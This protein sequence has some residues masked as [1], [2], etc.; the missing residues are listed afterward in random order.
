ML[1]EAIRLDPNFGLAYYQLAVVA[2]AMG[3]P[4]EARR[5][6]GIA[7]THVDRMSERDAM[8]VRVMVALDAKKSDEATSLLETLVARYPDTED[9]W[10]MLANQQTTRARRAEIAARAVTALPFSPGLYNIYGYFLLHTDRFDEAIRAFQTYVKL[11]PTEPNALD[12]LAEGYLVTGDLT[13]ALD[14]YEAALKGG[15]VSGAPMGKAWTLAVAGRYPEAAAALERVAPQARHYVSLVLSRLGR[16][17]EAAREVETSRQQAVDNSNSRLV[18][19]LD[20]V[21]AAYAFERQDCNAVA[22]LVASAEKMPA[23][24]PTGDE[25]WVV[26]DLLLAPVTRGK[27]AS[28][29]PSRASRTRTHRVRRIGLPTTG[30]SRRSTARSR[31][32]NGITEG[33]QG[34]AAGE[35]ARKMWFSRGPGVDVQASF[36]ANNLILRDGRPRGTRARPARRSDRGYRDSHQGRSRSGR[37]CSTRGTSWRWRALTRPVSET[38]PAS[39]ISAFS[40]SGRTPTVWFRRSWAKL[41]P[42]SD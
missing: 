19:A 9:A 20:L 8:L 42:R 35:P 29:R 5:M 6:L 33:L 30:G 40:S 38:R 41:A 36:L 39:S 37:R 26:T 4:A 13:S 24:S 18:G 25:G 16:Y 1:E 10:F 15:A 21:K 17:R 31:W 32:P 11:R 7:A 27:G 3:Q 34:F 14:R 28:P 22:P 23:R 12:S 2:F